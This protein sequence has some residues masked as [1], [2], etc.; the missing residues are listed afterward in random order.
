MATLDLIN[1]LDVSPASPGR[2][3]TF[4]KR[5]DIA[6]I[7]DALGVTVGAADVL[8]LGTL[9]AGSVILASNMIVR[10][11]AALAATA[12]IG[13]GGALIGAT[14]VNAAGVTASDTSRAL[15]ADTTVTATFAAQVPAGLVADV[16]IT[17]T[18]QG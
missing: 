14:A 4:T 5:V 3:L 10:E 7:Q 12:A 2:V 9:P 1:K 13:C 16:A 18:L 17:Y 8:N 6:Q 11:P 15:S